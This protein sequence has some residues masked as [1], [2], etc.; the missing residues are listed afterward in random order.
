[1]HPISVGGSSLLW[2]TD[3]IGPLRET[4]EARIPGVE[5]IF[6]QGCAGDVAPFDWWFGNEDASR[7][8][9]EVRD[10]LGRGI[11]EAALKLYPGD[12]DRPPTRASPPASKL[13]ELRRR[14]HAYDEAEIRAR[15]AEL[16]AQRRRPTG[17]RSG[18][19]RCTR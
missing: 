4:V 16:E 15:I 5:C 12:R 8:G 1:M 19:R 18:A 11:G 7:H 2:D 10:R 6:L 13:L 14:R 9:Y 17:P 3:Y